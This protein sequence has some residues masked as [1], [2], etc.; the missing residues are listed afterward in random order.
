MSMPRTPDHH[1]NRMKW[2]RPWVRTP[3]TVGPAGSHLLEPLPLRRHGARAPGRPARISR[4]R[5]ESPEWPPGH[6]RTEPVRP[7]RNPP[8]DGYSY[9][10]GPSKRDIIPVASRSRLPSRPRQTKDP[11]VSHLR[12]SP[13][14]TRTSVVRQRRALRRPRTRGRG[15]DHGGVGAHEGRCRP[16]PSG[17]SPG[18]ATGRGW[19]C[20]EPHLIPNG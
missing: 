20:G 9:S 4:L 17:R 13:N 14:G 1:P 18:G 16:A 6:G 2:C 11:T 19:S 12:A 10:S 15:V 5:V 7:S 3:W 8:A